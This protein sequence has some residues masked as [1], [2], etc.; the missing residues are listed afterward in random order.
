MLNQEERAAKFFDAITKDAEERHEEMTRKTRETVE[1]G[2]E[3]AKTKAHFQAQAAQ[4]A[5]VQ[6]HRRQ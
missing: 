1:S 6:P 2:L 3:K 4:G 5:G